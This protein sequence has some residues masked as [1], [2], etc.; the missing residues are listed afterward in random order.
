[1]RVLLSREDTV[2]LGAKRP[3]IAAGVRA[4]G[5][6]VVRA[7]RT[8]GLAEAVGA[9]APGLVVEEHDV[10]GPPTSVALRGAGWAEAEVLLA[11]VRGQRRVRVA[12]DGA[13]AE[14]EVGPDGVWLRVDAGDPLDEVVLRSYCVGAAHMGLSWVWSEG[15]AV[16][17][18]GR[19]LDLTVRS[20]DILRP[21]DMPAVQVEV[22]ASDRPPV[23]VS[24]AVTA[25]VAASAWIGQ[26]CPQDWPT[27]GSSR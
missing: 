11:A 25:A 26:G 23:P 20:F 7:V 19:P 27:G 15:L 22:V 9:V 3:P 24:A 8:A 10:A 6:G 13:V 21:G 16:A 17:D 4:D 14:A 1:M 18:D 5:T 12:H 2:R